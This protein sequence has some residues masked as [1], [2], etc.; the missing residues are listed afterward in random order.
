MRMFNFIIAAL[1]LS[2]FVGVASAQGPTASEFAESMPNGRWWSR[3]TLDE[4]R[5]WLFG[6]A[7]GIKTAAAFVSGADP[8]NKLLQQFVLDFQP[9]DK[10]TTT[11]TVEG[12][13][14]FY[15]DTPENAPVPV[16]GALNYVETKAKGAKQSELDDLASSMRKAAST[17]PEKKP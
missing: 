3:R 4:K 15:Q 13:D 6:Y 10:L 14:H 9:T 12:I 7:D 1:L 17:T 2:T 5:V 16:A 11:E 8:T